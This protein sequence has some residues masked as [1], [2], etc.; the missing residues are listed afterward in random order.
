MPTGKEGVFVPEDQGLPVDTEETEVP[1]R[2]RAV[3]SAKRG[4]P[5]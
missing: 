2:K 5:G 3:H 4:T 1:H